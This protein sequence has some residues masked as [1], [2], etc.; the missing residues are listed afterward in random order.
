MT[1]DDQCVDI[2]VGLNDRQYMT[3]NRALQDTGPCHGRVTIGPRSGST[4]TH[5]P[6]CRRTETNQPEAEYLASAVQCA[7]ALSRVMNSARE[8]RFATLLPASS[9]HDIHQTH[10]HSVLEAQFP[11]W[12]E[13]PA[14]SSPSLRCRSFLQLTPQESM[15]S[16]PMWRSSDL[17]VVLR[18]FI[19][20]AREGSLGNSHQGR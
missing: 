19:E 8:H 17:G 5:D 20:T 14:S 11:A 7:R 13:F 6:V 15:C 10:I 4:S 3:A 9:L 16:P 18:Q 2:H 1:V 12:E